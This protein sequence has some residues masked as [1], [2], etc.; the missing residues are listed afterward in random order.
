MEAVALAARNPG[1]DTAR[2]M[3]QENVEVVRE[4]WNAFNRG[5]LDT[6]IEFFDPEIE[7]HDLPTM[8]G[9]GVHRGRDPFRRHV[10]G[11]IEVWGEVRMETEEIRSI[12]DRVVSRGRYVGVGRESGIPVENPTSGAIYEFRG[13]RIVRVRQF[14]EHAEALEAAGLRE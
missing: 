7:W 10:E 4:V 3:S 12:G 5:D 14:V 6:F 2:A 11:F 1:R 9:G 13:G 8:P